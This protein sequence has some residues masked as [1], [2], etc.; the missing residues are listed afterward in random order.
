M[1]LIKF[2]ILAVYSS[3]KELED[4]EAEIVKFKYNLANGI[5]MCCTAIFKQLQ[6]VKSEHLFKPYIEDILKFILYIHQDQE[7]TEIVR[8]ISYLIYYFFSYL[9]FMLYFS[10]FN[11]RFYR[12]F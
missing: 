1:N 8:I 7:E 4:E 10:G 5:I 6:N 2:A 12:V 3:P 11:N 9:V